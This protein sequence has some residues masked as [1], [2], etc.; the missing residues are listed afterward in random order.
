MSEYKKEEDFESLSNK[1]P[2]TFCIYP[3]VHINFRADGHLAPCFRSRPLDNIQRSKNIEEAWNSPEWRQLRLNM[4]SG[5]QTK[6]C[7]TCWKAEA[8]NTKSYRQVALELRRYRKTT[9]EICDPICKDIHTSMS[10]KYN[11]IFNEFANLKYIRQSLSY[12]P[13]LFD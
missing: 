12:Q 13:D 5:I 1:N 7:S 4:I 10:L 11:H 8:Q 2:D 9:T 3:L 6:T